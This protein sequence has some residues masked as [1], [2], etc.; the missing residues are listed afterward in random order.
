MPGAAALVDE[1]YLD[2]LPPQ[3]LK[4]V[5]RSYDADDDCGLAAEIR[6]LQSCFDEGRRVDTHRLEG[7]AHTKPHPPRSPARPPCFHW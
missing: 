1:A 3:L 2:T 4:L 6:A 7:P 5:A